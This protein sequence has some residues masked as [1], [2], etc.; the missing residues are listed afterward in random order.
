MPENPAQLI[1]GFVL[2][3]AGEAGLARR[4]QLYLALAIVIGDESEAARLNALAGAI[5]S[6][7][8]QT[9]RELQ[10][11]DD[12]HRQLVLDFKRRTTAGA[13]RTGKARGA[14]AA[15][16]PADFAGPRLVT[17]NPELETRNRKFETRNPEPKLPGRT[18][19]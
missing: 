3:K 1:C 17:L 14:S 7:D 13:V 19:E 11:F 4:A 2:E 12:R 6:L 5:L 18:D 10:A 9:A 15:A 8:A 16:R